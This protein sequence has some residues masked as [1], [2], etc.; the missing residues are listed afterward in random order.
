MNSMH[1]GVFLSI[2]PTCLKE[3]MSTTH[4][5]IKFIIFFFRFLFVF[6][7]GFLFFLIYVF[8]FA[9]LISVSLAL[10]STIGKIFLRIHPIIVGCLL[11]RYFLSLLDCFICVVLCEFRINSVPLVS[12]WIQIS[13]F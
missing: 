5:I 11:L 1:Q 10:P 12:D 6:L 8:F 7:H 2:Q 13:V 3:E 9:P 4:K